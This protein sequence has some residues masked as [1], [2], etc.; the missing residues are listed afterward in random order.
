MGPESRRFVDSLAEAGQKVW[1]VLPLNPTGQENSPYQCRSA[2]AA[3]PL[4]ISPELL[5]EHGYLSAKEL[6]SAPHFPS[7]HVEFPAVRLHKES[8]LKKA[9]RNFTETRDYLRFEQKH[10]HWLESYALFMGLRE[11]NRGV[12]WTKFNPR[13][14]PSAETIRYHK[15]VQF[16]FFRQWHALRKYCAERKIL[17]MGD[18]PFYVEHNGADVWGN[19]SL[20]DLGQ[21]GEPRTVGGVPPDYFSEDGQLWGTPTYRWKKMKD[22][23]F[24]WWIDRFK[25]T[26]EVVDLMRLDHFRGF[27]AFWSVDARASTARKGRWI[28]GPGA[29]FFQTVRKEIKELPFV[30]ENLGTITP[31]VDILRRRFGFPGMAVLQFGFDEEG[32]HRPNNYVQEQVSFTGTHDNDTTI[33]WW[34]TL[35]QSA[36]MP[37]N[38][39]DVATLRRVKSY[40]QT[41][42]QDIHWSFI[43]AIMTSVAN[44]AII[45]L[46][47]VLRSWIRGPDEF[48]W[49]CQ[50]KLALAISGQ[51]NPTGCIGTLARFDHRFREARNLRARYGQIEGQVQETSR[52]ENIWSREWELN[53]RPADYEM[54]RFLSSLLFSISAILSISPSFAPFR[55]SNVQRKV[56]RVCL[57]GVI[58]T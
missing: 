57:V 40:L 3:N 30:A 4:L 7:S 22:T 45:P 42:G 53:P 8:L 52:Q 56:Q 17:I 36:R 12:P 5:V 23:G 24:R 43:Q 50:R 49:T 6:R 13:T 20:F 48:T 58:E 2:F 18:M 21:N 16:E 55:R 10:S 26:L 37:K 35:Q 33:G 27:E 38:A 9:F 41:D 1:C 54:N 44:L 31:K 39:S 11:A 47:D 28:K 32:T 51:A 15:F 29:E 19:P 25:S 14:A 46:Q 34:R